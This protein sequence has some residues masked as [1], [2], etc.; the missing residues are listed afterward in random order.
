MD[1][2]EEAAL[3]GVPPAN[4]KADQGNLPVRKAEDLRVEA[5]QGNPAVQKAEAN[6]GVRNS[7]GKQKVQAAVRAAAEVPPIAEGIKTAITT[8]ATG[9]ADQASKWRK[10]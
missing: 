7:Q 3:P 5:D 10:T 2:E 4:P 9:T 1:V 6:Q 8:G